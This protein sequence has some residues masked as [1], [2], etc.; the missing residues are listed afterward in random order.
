MSNIILQILISAKNER[1][2]PRILLITTIFLKGTFL[3]MK[4][5]KLNLK[6]FS[7]ILAF[8]RQV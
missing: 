8:D 3:K 2:Q 6:L 5:R 1:R 7:V 4:G